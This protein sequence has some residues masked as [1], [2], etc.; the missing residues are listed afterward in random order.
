[1]DWFTMEEHM[2]QNRSSSVDNLTSKLPPRNNYGGN[3]GSS[4][5]LSKPGSSHER[6][7]NINRR[8]KNEYIGFKRLDDMCN[9]EIEKL[10]TILSIEVDLF[11]KLLIRDNSESQDVYVLIIKLL[12]KVCDSPFTQH[13]GQLLSS[14]CQKEFIDQL[15]RYLHDL[16]LQ[17]RNE[18]ERNKYFWKNVDEFWENILFVFDSILKTIPNTAVEALPKIVKTLTLTIRN[19]EIEQ[20]IYVADDVKDKID[21][22]YL[23]LTLCIE[24]RERKLKSDPEQLDLE[25][26]DDFRKISLYPNVEEITT[27]EK[28]FIRANIV[29][30]K[31]KTVD[32]YLDVQFRLLRE[33]FVAPLRSGICNFMNQLKTK[34]RQRI[35]NVRIYR[36]VQFLKSKSVNDKI[37]KIVKFN[38]NPKKNKIKIENSRKLMYGSLVCFTNNNFKTV[39]FG[40]II[41]RDLDL[42]KNGEVGIELRSDNINYNQDYIMIECSVYF[43]PYY[44][45]LKALQTMDDDA[46]P[47]SEYIIE[48][49]DVSK[50]PKYLHDREAGLVQIEYKDNIFYPLITSTWPTPQQLEFDESQH[51]AFHS[52][53]TSE[54]CVIQGPPGTGKTFIGLKITE[55]LLN[56]ASIWNTGPILVICFT[57]HALD[58]FLEGMLGFTKE[59]CRIGGQSK[60]ENLKP[61]NI[62]ELRFKRR[63]NHLLSQALLNKREKL[64]ECMENVKKT[65]NFIDNLTSCYC[66]FKAIAFTKVDPLI[67]GSKFDINTGFFLNW[68]LSGFDIR[69]NIGNINRR[70]QEEPD[71]PENEQSDSDESD[72]FLDALEEENERKIDDGDHDIIDLENLKFCSLYNVLLDVNGIQHKHEVLLK[73]LQEVY[74]QPEN[75][76][77]FFNARQEEIDNIERQIN[78]LQYLQYRIDQR[79]NGEYPRPPIHVDYNNPNL[80][81]P[82]ERWGL[83]WKWVD[84]YIKLL[85]EKINKY[86]AEYRQL[87]R[88]YEEINIIEDIKIMKRLSVIGMTTTGAARYQT[89]LQ[90]IK[91]PIVIVEEAAE[92]LESHIVVALTK[93]CQHLILIGDHK[94]LRPTTAVYHLAKKY[95]LE[96]S[97]FERMVSNGMHCQTLE[98]QHRMRPEIAKLIVPAVYPK[99]ENHSSVH[100]YPPIQGLTTNM[101]FISHNKEEELVQDSSSRL[102]E[103]EARFLIKLARHLILQGYEP[104]EITIL[105]TYSGQM[106]QLWKERREHSILKDVRIT[107]VD[108][109]Q[110]EE[111][112]IILL[113]LVRS[114]ADGNIGFLKTDNRVNVALSRA[115]EGMFIF[116]NFTLPDKI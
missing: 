83:Y 17:N 69:E 50:P 105:T 94:Q 68:L 115:K 13:I 85:T 28:A 98:V 25:P 92:V 80:L 38:L 33:D 32:H 42:L 30:G 109:F 16:T 43:E 100:Y 45:V 102:N 26:P 78:E 6:R 93:S 12:R 62:R 71:G 48:V 70:V 35:Y 101:F 9:M 55:L 72:I 61:F 3:Y 112:K 84:E 90:A 18:R 1:M 37:I 97:L 73:Q 106:F 75:Q 21:N 60:N 31:Y 15:L 34:D 5:D 54:F 40:T 8:P 23:K 53:L 91:C 64:S 56:N 46:F 51:K 103:H 81:T 65:Q 66:L 7:H 11:N 24:E 74:A 95:N 57:N 4:Q 27:N 89:L 39:L 14:F 87:Y 111:N 99:L 47:L 29:K 67:I 36:P 59:I 10:I 96:I 19:I 86:E 20:K 110:G 58:Q 108:N 44:H 116:F 104:N 77:D 2:G 113:S 82:N 114:N 79:K 22:F 52:A 49:S 41:E 88:E 107:V 76:F 63:R